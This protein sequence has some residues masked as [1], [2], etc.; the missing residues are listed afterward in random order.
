[1]KNMLRAAIVALS[2]ASIGS[3]YAGAGDSPAAN[4]QFTEIPGVLARAPVQDAPSFA[5]A[6]NGPVIHTYV[7]N[8]NRRTWLFRSNQNQGNGS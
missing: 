3:A 5:M 8:A 6:Q 7:T 1:M 2:I 4:T